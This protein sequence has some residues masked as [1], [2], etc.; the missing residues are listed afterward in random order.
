LDV[1]ETVVASLSQAPLDRIEGLVLPQ[2][3]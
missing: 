3:G 1:L 2:G